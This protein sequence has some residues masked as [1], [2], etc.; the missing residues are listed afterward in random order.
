MKTTIFITW[1]CVLLTTAA[2]TGC[3]GGG[4]AGANGGDDTGTTSAPN[5]S[6]DWDTLVWDQ[7]NWS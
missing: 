1:L 4:S 5:G 2:L 7:D 3:G 6:S